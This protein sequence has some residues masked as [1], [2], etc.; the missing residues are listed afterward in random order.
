VTGT[1]GQRYAIWPT[2]GAKAY[3]G[4]HAGAGISV[5]TNGISVFEH[6]VSYVPSLLVYDAPVEGWTHV[7]VVYESRTP[8][9]YVNGKLVKTGVTSEANVHPGCCFGGT[10]WN[11]FYKGVLDD[12]RIFS[13][14]LSAPEIE[15]LAKDEGSSGGKPAE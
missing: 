6:G 7:A 14:A 13:T 8:K 11:S 15:K 5:G 4:G 3:G 9:L 10:A 2:Q 1:S 12:V